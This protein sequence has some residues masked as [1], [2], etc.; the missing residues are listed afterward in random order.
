[1]SISAAPLAESGINERR[2]SILLV[3]FCT[4]LGA[5][6]QVFIKLGV[7]TLPHVQGVMPNVLAM[8]SNPR[9]VFGY[10]LYGMSAVLLVL[11]LRHG[12]LSLLYPVIAL[13]YVWV[14]I[15][16]VM[17]FHENMSPVRIAGI[18]T[19]VVGVAVLGRGNKS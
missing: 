5:A 6:A 8:A 14:A 11:A 16:S 2:R 10:S 15:L 9:L 1:M 4:V 13:T 18:A 17:V 3:M 12:E 19:I 7:S